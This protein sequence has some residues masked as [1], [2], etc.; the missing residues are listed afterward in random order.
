MIWRGNVAACG[1]LLK[2]EALD[3]YKIIYINRK[4]FEPTRPLISGN[5]P[6]HLLNGQEM[7]ACSYALLSIPFSLN[8]LKIH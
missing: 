5:Y 6:A 4:P 1:T 2:W 7:A 8:V 3:S